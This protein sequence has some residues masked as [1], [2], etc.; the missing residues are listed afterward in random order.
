MRRAAAIGLVA[1]G[2]GAFAYE[3][4]AEPNDVAHTT[5]D[6]VVVRF[7]SPETGG[8]ARPRYVTA[9]ALA[10]ETRLVAL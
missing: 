10:Y 6:A 5:T 4:A 9:R 3:A 7:H 8:A 2:L 1:I